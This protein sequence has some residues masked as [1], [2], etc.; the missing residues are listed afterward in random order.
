[1]D[2]NCAICRKDYDL[3]ELE[4]LDDEGEKYSRYVCGSCWDVI[5]GIAQRAVKAMIEKQ[6]E[7]NQ[8]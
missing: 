5:A 4:L 8:G 6:T 2:K 3:F 7:D 1:M